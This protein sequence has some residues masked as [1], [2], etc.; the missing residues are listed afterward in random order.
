MTKPGYSGRLLKQ[1]LD[2]SWPAADW[3][4]A[5]PYCQH[6]GLHFPNIAEVE[7]AGAMSVLVCNQLM[8]LGSQLWDPEKSR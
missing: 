8:Y 1:V 3:Q 6:T 7:F 5:I 4:L 2:M